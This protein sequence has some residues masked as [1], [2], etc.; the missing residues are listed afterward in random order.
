MPRSQARSAAG[1]LPAGRDQDK[2]QRRYSPEVRRTMILKDAKACLLE[3]GLDNTT[4]R[5]IA[6][7][8]S[9][10]PGTITYHFPSVDDILVEVLAEASADYLRFNLSR[11][12]EVESAVDRLL[13]L[14]HGGLPSDGKA[15]QMWRLWVACWSRAP[16]E[17]RLAAVHA[18]RHEHERAAIESI[19]EAGKAAGEFR[20]DVDSR[21]VAW[22]LLGLLDGLGLQAYVSEESMPLATVRDLLTARVESL[23]P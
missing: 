17:S 15:R 4:V 21:A 13:A 8:C 11:A 2:P 12:T 1:A 20:A 14:L 19:V 6:A 16:Y 9:V 23:R 7:W 5:D 18:E 3:N 10:S 22:E